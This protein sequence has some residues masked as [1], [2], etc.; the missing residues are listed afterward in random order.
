MKGKNESNPRINLS[1]RESSIDKTLQMK[2][3]YCSLL[4]LCVQKRTTGK[5]ETIS[6]GFYSCP[7]WFLLH[8]ICTQIYNILLY[9]ALLFSPLIFIYDFFL[10]VS[11]S[12]IA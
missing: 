7:F 8:E 4:V 6:R 5:R 12:Y 1:V 3:K 10:F 9:A 2:D 11:Q